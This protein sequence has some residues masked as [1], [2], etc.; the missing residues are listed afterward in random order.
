MRINSF[1]IRF[2]NRIIGQFQIDNSS[3]PIFGIYNVIWEWN[4][5]DVKINV[6]DSI[7]SENCQE[8]EWCQSK[9]EAIKKM[10]DSWIRTHNTEV[11]S[12]MNSHCSISHLL[13]IQNNFILSI[14]IHIVISGIAFKWKSKILLFSPLRHL[15]M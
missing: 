10:C 8:W 9:K 5:L 6:M 3:K 7:E 14:T 1:K 2:I 12:L 11:M 13:F 4:K 15:S